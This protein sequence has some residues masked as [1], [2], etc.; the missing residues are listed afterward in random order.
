MPGIERPAGLPQLHHCTQAASSADPRP[1]EF[2]RCC[3]PADVCCGH[4]ATVRVPSYPGVGR[5]VVPLAATAG[6]PSG[7]SGTGSALPTLASARKAAASPVSWWLL[8]SQFTATH[9]SSVTGSWGG[10]C[11]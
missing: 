8:E 10:A 5:L 9:P 2:P 11:I 1:P 6:G 4:P 7:G 3:V